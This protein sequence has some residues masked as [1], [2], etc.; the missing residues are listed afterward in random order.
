[1]AHGIVLQR[2]KENGEEGLEKTAEHQRLQ[3]GRRWRG[4]LGRY[5][6]PKIEAAIGVPERTGRG[7]AGFLEG[8]SAAPGSLRKRVERQNALYCDV[9]GRILQ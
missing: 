6:S 8:A 7:H 1:V 2:A 9:V 3:R 5:R 4:G